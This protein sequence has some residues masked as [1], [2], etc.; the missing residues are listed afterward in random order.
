MLPPPLSCQLRAEYGIS[1][2][3]TVVGFELRGNEPLSPRP[4]T[5]ASFI[6]FYCF[7]RSLAMAVQDRY[8]RFDNIDIEKPDIVSRCSRCGQEFT[9]APKPAERVDDVLLRIRTE[10]EAHKCRT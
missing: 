1:V 7:R 6:L 8:L 5:A 2:A 4:W 9:A 10:F 3:S